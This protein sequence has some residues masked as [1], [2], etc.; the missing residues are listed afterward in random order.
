V[1]M[2]FGGNNCNNIMGPLDFEKGKSVPEPECMSQCHI[3]DC[4]S[5]KT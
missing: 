3:G 5:P 2:G 4:L 1:G